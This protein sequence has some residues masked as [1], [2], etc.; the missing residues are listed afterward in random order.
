MESALGIQREDGGFEQAG[1]KTHLLHGREDTSNCLGARL[2]VRLGTDRHN[3]LEL[4]A[5]ERRQ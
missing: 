1:G 2:R 3:W 4:R 5:L